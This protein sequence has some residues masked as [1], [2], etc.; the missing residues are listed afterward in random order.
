M[1]KYP[2]TCKFNHLILQPQSYLDNKEERNLTGASSIDD[3][4][5]SE[6]TEGPDEFL[7]PRP[8][9]MSYES[10]SFTV[11]S[12][13]SEG[14]VMGMLRK[15]PFLSGFLSEKAPRPRRRVWV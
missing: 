5:A 12:E 13:S 10:T 1:K 7:G 3:A 8:T 9:M 14:E 6:T 4:T 15:T 2:L 11:T